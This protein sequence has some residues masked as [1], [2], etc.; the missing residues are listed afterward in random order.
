M[1]TKS[2]RCLLPARWFLQKVEILLLLL[3]VG[4]QFLFPVPA[5]AVKKQDVTVSKGLKLTFMVDKSMEFIHG[6]IVIFYTAPVKNPAVPYLVMLNLF[7]EEL[8]GGSGIPGILRKMGNDFE[9]E[10]NP[11]YLVLKVNFLPDKISNFARLI[12]SLYKYKPLM[13]IMAYTESQRYRKLKDAQEQFKRS[14]DNYWKYFYEMETWKREIAYQIAYQWLFANHFPG[15]GLIS[16]EFLQKVKLED[17]RAFYLQTYRFPNSHVILKGDVKPHMA[18]AMLEDQLG[19]FKNQEPIVPVYEPLVVHDERKV[20]I[21]NIDAR[22]PPVLFWFESIPPMNDNGYMPMLVLD[23]IL[24][25]YPYG[26]IYHSPGKN[27]IGYVR[28]KTEIENHRS[29]SVICNI[30][31]IA[32]RDIEKFIDLVDGEK[33]RMERSTISRKEVLYASSYFHGKI[34]VDSRHYDSDFN[35]EIVESILDLKTDQ[36]SNLVPEETMQLTMRVIN[37]RQTKEESKKGIV[38][39]VGNARQIIPYFKNIKPIVLSYRK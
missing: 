36:I 21:F 3:V 11:D 27:G 7:N 5:S 9:L 10:Q 29:I 8:N 39:I 33:K 28:I 15:K 38:V 24:Y 25:G 34:K 31:A 23:R 30:T 17:L 20:V 12:K 13:N 14:V 35:Q 4:H 22:E 19:G 37:H 26:K 32:P 18:I 1:F 6:E 2:N 16:Q